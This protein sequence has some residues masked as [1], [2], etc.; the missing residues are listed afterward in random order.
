MGLESS[1]LSPLYPL[2]SDMGKRHIVG[3]EASNRSRLVV[4]CAEKSQKWTI[5]RMTHMDALISSPSSESREWFREHVRGWETSCD[6]TW[7][8]VVSWWEHYCQCSQSMCRY[9]LLLVSFRKSFDY[10]F[11]SYRV[12]AVNKVSQ[13]LNLFY[14]VPEYMGYKQIL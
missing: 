7:V 1:T 8:W 14:I 6:G 4:G 10:C 11:S 12:P 5:E 9:L 3:H 2:H 13:A